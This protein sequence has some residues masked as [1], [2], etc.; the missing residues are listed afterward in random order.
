MIK[1]YIGVLLVLLPITVSSLLFVLNL[2]YSWYYSKN[3]KAYDLIHSIISFLMV[4]IGI[5][6]LLKKDRAIFIIM[7]AMIF[8]VYQSLGWSFNSKRYVSLLELNPDTS[9]VITRYDGGAFTASSFV[10]IEVSERYYLLLL[11]SS[12]VKTFENVA[13]GKLW[14]KNKNVIGV[15]LLT[16]SKD[17]IVDEVNL[18]DISSR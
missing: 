3:Y 1:K 2:E 4:V 13:D 5:S 9:V 14:L 10:N 17:K 15:E 16:Y 8:I 18:V 6:F 11:K 7:L 12:V